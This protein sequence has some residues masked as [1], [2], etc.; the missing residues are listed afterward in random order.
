MTCGIALDLSGRLWETSPQFRL[1]FGIRPMTGSSSRN[2]IVQFAQ[3]GVA[4]GVLIF[5][6]G[7]CAGWDRHDDTVRENDLS[8]AAR[9][10]RSQE[11]GVPTASSYWNFDDRGRQIERDLDVK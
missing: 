11:G 7:G 5:S 1:L 3:W 4:A 8:A 10:A 9:Q 2:R 6:L